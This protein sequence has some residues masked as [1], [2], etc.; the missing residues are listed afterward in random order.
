VSIIA[1]IKIV[2]TRDDANQLEKLELGHRVDTSRNL[3][4][5][6]EIG[7]TKNVNDLRDKNLDGPTYGTYD[8]V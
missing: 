3:P 2:E 6:N 7:S 8:K 4:T 1:T 5:I